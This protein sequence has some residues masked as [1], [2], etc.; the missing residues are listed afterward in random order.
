MNQATHVVVIGAGIVGLST[1]YHLQQKGISCT[2]IDS[3]G[4]AGETS[5]GNA[6]SVSVASIF[7][8][9]TPGIA[10]KA[11][12]MLMDP[13]SP[14]K[15]NWRRPAT[16][17]PWLWQFWQAATWRRVC[18]EVN[19]LAALNRDAATCWQA[20]AR[21]IDA[22]SLLQS[23][24]FL[25]VYSDRKN[26]DD[27]AWQRDWMR[28]RGFRFELLNRDA[29]L[30]LEPALG[31]SFECGVLETDSLMVSDPGAFCRHLADVLQQ[32]GVKIVNA[33]VTQLQH[34]AHGVN[35]MHQ[36]GN[37]NASHVVIAAGVWTNRLLA[38]FDVQLPIIPARGYHLMFQPEP[39]VVNRPVLWCERYMVLTP[40]QQGL[41]MTSI[42]ELT[43]L[44]CD[45][46]FGFIRRLREEAK[47][48]FPTL[49]FD[50]QSEWMGN[51]PCT[52]D[53]LPVIG[54]VR[55]LPI[56]VASGH[57]HL[58]LTQG[59]VTGKLAAQ[60]LSEKATDIDLTPFSVARF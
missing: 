26:F 13:L 7:P 33:T 35:V 28:E 34:L 57:G 56:Y 4:P 45:P 38:P 53:S 59:P 55:D 6:G 18:A 10:K 9:A 32:R 15:V 52:P 17:L 43:S 3:K 8:Q 2:V 31:L 58:G 36:H 22:E 29:L 37:I 23:V 5:F 20:M 49:P 50:V 11:L 39:N 27:D 46:R 1:A 44:D 14:L 19:A 54:Q 41:R 51:R 42:K 12:Q 16:V 47:K 60:L 25:H 40:M 30:A 24:G 21:D 48:V